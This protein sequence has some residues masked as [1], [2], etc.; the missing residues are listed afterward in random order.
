MRI[1]L[2]V[3]S[4]G[5]GAA[6]RA[7]AA[8]AG[9]EVLCFGR[10]DGH[11]PLAGVRDSSVDL[12]QIANVRYVLASFR[13]DA[14][15]HLAWSADPD[16][17]GDHHDRDGL[18]LAGKLFHTALDAGVPHVLGLGTC[19]EYGPRNG[20]LRE[21]GDCL[22]VSR[23][24]LMRQVAHGLLSALAVEH[25]AHY[26]WMRAFEIVGGHT[27]PLP[28]AD[29]GRPTHL[30]VAPTTS[31]SDRRD[32]IEV[33]DAARAI[34]HAAEQ[35]LFGPLNL[36]QGPVCTREELLRAIAVQA[37]A[38]GITAQQLDLRHGAQWLGDPSR[39]VKTGFVP[40]S[41]TAEQIAGSIIKRYE[42]AKAIAA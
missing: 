20:A 17:H 24:G 31:D 11:R 5:L 41:R 33:H 13:A 9:H 42:P 2:T 14:F 18:D 23:H 7:Q 35:R 36:C 1:A 10:T 39:L 6:L 27:G 37:R 28:C 25:G 19:Q 22:P 12:N 32:Y 26:T 38:R 8:L 21:D 4:S 15:I 40:M 34:L 29:P 30:Q 3:G 16:A